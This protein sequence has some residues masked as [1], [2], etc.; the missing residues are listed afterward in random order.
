MPDYRGARDALLKRA[1]INDAIQFVLD[2][3]ASETNE[4]GNATCVR[5]NKHKTGIDAD[6]SMHIDPKTGAAW[7][8]SCA[9][10]ASSFVGLYQEVARVK[11]QQA[12]EILWDELIE[13]LVPTDEIN[14][15]H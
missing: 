5:A 9:F 13:P 2:A 8:F 1:N 7:C 11:Y 3:Y 4:S 15:A 14:A 6:P 12:V 10:K